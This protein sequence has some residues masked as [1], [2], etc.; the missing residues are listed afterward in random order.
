MAAK[1]AQPDAAE[2]PK[3]ET[4]PAPSLLSG[5]VK[6]R[7]H[8]PPRMLLYGIHGIGKSTFAAAAPSPIFI[9]TEDGANEIDVPKFPQVKSRIEVMDILRALYKEKHDY[10]TV[11]LDSADWFEDFIQAELRAEFTEKELGFGRESLFAEGKMSDVLG[12]F[13]MLRTKR[14]MAVI[15]IAHS[16]VKRFDSPITEP[17]DRYQPK[18]TAR[19][20]SLLQEWADA[21]AFC[22]YD[23]SVKKEDVGFSREVRRGISS[24]DRV[25][26]TEE[27][28]AFYAK[29]RYQLPVEMPLSWEEFA[30]HVPYYTP[31]Q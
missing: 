28:P 26:Y 7:I 13:S 30:K 12:A 6:G 31:Q 16:E 4:K 15:V 3:E 17:F 8:Q 23:I 24:G 5:V 25:M 11:V 19:L 1:P 18:L 21:V 2:A 27:R 9:P 14:D 10:K 22:N 29:N 20:S